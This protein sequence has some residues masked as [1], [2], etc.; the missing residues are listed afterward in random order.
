MSI[1]VSASMKCAGFVVTKL[2]VINTRITTEN[3]AFLLAR[4]ILFSFYSWQYLWWSR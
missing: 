3:I 4:S 2:L 1:V